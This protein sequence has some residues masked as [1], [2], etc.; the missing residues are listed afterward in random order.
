MCVVGL[1][2]GCDARAQALDVCVRATVLQGTDVVE[3]SLKYRRELGYT[4][5]SLGEMAAF[6]AYAQAF[7]RNF[8]ALVDTY[9]TLSSGV[10]NFICVA[11][12]LRDIGFEPVGIRLDSGDLAYLSKEAR[13]MFQKVRTLLLS[14]R[15]T[16]AMIGYACRRWTS[17]TA[18]AS[19]AA[20]SWRPT[21]STSGCCTPSTTRATRSTP[22]ASVPTWCVCFV[23]AQV[24]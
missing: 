16:C 21:T 1:G 15:H 2:E 10:P 20:R 23:H 19:Q 13:R 8:L 17:G 22:S 24:C 4:I 18:P 5:S 11:L 3:L 9:D 6:I 7:P 14:R 12:A